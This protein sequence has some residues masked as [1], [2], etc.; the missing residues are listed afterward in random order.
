MR[1]RA[2][3][4]TEV[5]SSTETGYCA[6]PCPRA[7][8][9]IFHHLTP[10]RRALGNAVLALLALPSVC[11]GQITVNGDELLLPQAQAF[12]TGLAKLGVNLLAMRG[13]RTVTFWTRDFED[14]QSFL[15]H[16]EDGRVKVGA[17]SSAGA[18][19]AAAVLL[20]RAEL[21]G[22]HVFW[23]DFE[24]ADSPDLEYR[25]FMVD[26]GRNPHSPEALR[27]VVDMMW[28]YGGNFLHLH[29]T[30]DQLISWPSKAFPKLQEERAGW[31]W[32]DF[33][34]LESYS[35]ARGV[36]VVPE[37][38]VPGHSTLLRRH[39]PGVFGESTTDLASLPEAQEGVETL[40]DEM[41][42]VFQATPYFHIGGD[43]AYGVPEA[44]QREFINRLNAFIKSRGRRTVV[45]EGPRNGAGEDRVDLDVLH[46]NWRTINFPAQDML[47]AG[48]EIV[49]AAWHPMYIVDHYPRTMFT[50]VDVRECFEWDPQRFKHIW[51][52]IPTFANPHRTKSAK[53]ILGFCMPWWEGREENLMALC[54]PRFA[55]AATAAWDLER[56]GGFEQYVEEYNASL[57]RFT[58]VAGV[59][60]PELPMAFADTQAGN[61]AFGCPV[62][63][64]AGATQPH[65]GPARLTNGL[66]DRFDHFLGYPTN[67]SPLKIVIQLREASAVNR[68]VIHEGGVGGSFEQY[69]LQLSLDGMNYTT[70][71]AATKG[72]RAENAFVVHEFEPQQAAYVR[73]ET[74]GCQDLTFP[75][76]SRL[77]EV[78][79]F[80]D[81]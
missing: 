8:A 77:V 75:S 12:E 66:T 38:D 39:Y 48:Y 69:R 46:I 65:F 57:A 21:K 43:E 64:S 47:D 36:T 44:T 27:Q 50:A 13:G 31:T 19:Q 55:A 45:W 10:L 78:Q 76:F 70:V 73:I 14:G 51:Q 72:S 18:A 1:G 81:Q 24:F 11:V 2:S 34:E 60:L 79:V 74:D 29:L 80:A 20:K 32:N 59:V 17:A 67:P 4:L 35:Q 26:M 25:S 63:P 58:Q 41:L 62:L 53:G 40:I 28:L 37:I 15:I 30:D 7:S 42:S 22:G 33:V 71:S 52:G 61:L 5:G 54:W 56:P 6:R 68:I 49:N 3:S 23:P 16:S 9:S